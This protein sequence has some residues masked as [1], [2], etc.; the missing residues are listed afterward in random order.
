MELQALRYAA[1]DSLMT[2]NELASTY[3]RHLKG[4]GRAGSGNVVAVASR[5]RGDSVSA[6]IENKPLH[7]TAVGADPPYEDAVV[8]VRVRR[9]L[10][11]TPGVVTQSLQ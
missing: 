8:T 7:G 1:M 9:S 3:A 2:S 4:P 10:A 5:R 6:A 11:S